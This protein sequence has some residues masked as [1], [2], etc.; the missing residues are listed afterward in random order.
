M[1]T[2]RLIGTLAPVSAAYAK[3][4]FWALCG[5]ARAERERERREKLK[6]FFLLGIVP[7]PASVC[8]VTHK[9]THIHER[10]QAYTHKDIYCK[11]LLCWQRG[12]V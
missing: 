10:A 3:G 11:C 2:G 4:A 6:H 1:L 5:S 9:S 7:N 12:P 8:T